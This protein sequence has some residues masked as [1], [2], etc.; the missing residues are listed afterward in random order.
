M[1]S[2][3]L[4]ELDLLAI[5]NRLKVATPGP[6]HADADQVFAR[7]EVLADICC[8]E[9]D[10]A[11]KDALFFAHAREDIERLLVEVRALRQELSAHVSS[12]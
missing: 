4:S 2:R 6:W 11:M 3:R 9:I 8:G 5:E 1:D 10:Q 12:G 7:E